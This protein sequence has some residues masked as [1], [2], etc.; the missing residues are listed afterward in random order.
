MSFRLSPLDPDLTPEPA[1]ETGTGADARP[2]PAPAPAPQW[3]SE[4]ADGSGSV[5]PGA[6]SGDSDGSG[7]G[8]ENQHGAGSGTGAV[9]VP[10]FTVPAQRAGLAER[11]WLSA[12]ERAAATADYQRRHRT[13]WHAIAVFITRPPET[14]AET[15]QHLKSRKWLQEWMTGGFRTFCEWEN[16][17]WYHL[18]ARP[19]RYALRLAEK[20]FL[21]R[22]LGFWAAVAF[23]VLCVLVKAL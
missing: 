8:S 4:P 6:G 18:V 19:G 22:Q 14:W 12:R 16:V 20:V 23:I 1:D 5:V 3:F 10:A 9:L 15:E 7:T 13:F 17:A 21:T 2:A 11:L